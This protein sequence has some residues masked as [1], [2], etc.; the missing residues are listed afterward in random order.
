[1]QATIGFL[2]GIQSRLSNMFLS[3]LSVIG[4]IATRGFVVSKNGL[5]SCKGERMSDVQ[6]AKHMLD[7]LVQ[8]E[9]RGDLDRA[10][11]DAERRTGIA[12][13]TFWSFRYRKPQDINL[14]VWRRLLAAYQDLC[15]RQRRKFEH[16]LEITRRLQAGTDTPLARAAAVIGGSTEG[17]GA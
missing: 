4:N 8:A 1:M 6:V 2:A 10:M 3:L 16:E 14:S 17:E 15:E 13:G 7:A 12:Y 5:Q 9:Y 11:W